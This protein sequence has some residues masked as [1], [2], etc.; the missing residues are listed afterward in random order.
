MLLILTDE[1]RWRRLSRQQQR[2]EDDT[3]HMELNLRVM[4]WVISCRLRSLDRLVWTGPHTRTHAEYS[5]LYF[6]SDS[7]THLEKEGER[8]PDLSPLCPAYYSHLNIITEAWCNLSISFLHSGKVGYL[9]DCM[10]G[11][12]GL[13]I[14]VNKC[15]CPGRKLLDI[16]ASFCIVAVLQFYKQTQ[17]LEF[18]FK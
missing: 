9:T 5:E 2:G 10:C 8:E 14:S 3:G 18:L 1:R 17:K 6:L 4:F 11:L 16:P 15:K 13:Q 12:A 7:D